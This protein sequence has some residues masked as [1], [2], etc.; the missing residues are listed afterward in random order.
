MKVMGPQLLVGFLGCG[1]LLLF[2][3]FVE[4]GGITGPKFVWGDF[5]NLVGGSF[6]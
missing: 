4:A 1:L 5:F 3:V 6:C 2:F